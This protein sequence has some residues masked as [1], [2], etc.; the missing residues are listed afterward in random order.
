[1]V[2][3]LYQDE[4]FVAVDKPGGLLVH[5]TRGAADR[6]FLLQDLRDQ[7]G[8]YLFPVH[9]LDRAASGVLVFGLSSEAAAAMQGALSSDDACKRYLVLVRGSTPDRWESRRPLS[10]EAKRKQDAHTEFE[11]L[12]EVSRCSLLSAR[13]FTGRRHQ[14]R[15]HLAHERHQVIGD[16]SYGKGKING[17]FRGNFDLP[18]L[19]LHAASLEIDHPVTGERLGIRAP[20]PAD[21]RGFLLR[22]PDVD[23]ELVAGL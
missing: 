20:L 6:R 5:R 13:I 4:T 11:K 15:R 9:R 18:R 10:N 22:L 1:M 3:I 16:T 23:P 7:L 19:F 12:A 14:I 17:Y 21:L 2:P 8:R